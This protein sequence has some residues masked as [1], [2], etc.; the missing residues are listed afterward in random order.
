[1]NAYEKLLIAEIETLE[2]ELAVELDDM[3][4]KELFVLMVSA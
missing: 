1:M 2:A 3:R 4:I